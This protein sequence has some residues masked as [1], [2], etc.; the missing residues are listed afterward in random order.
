MPN[1]SHSKDPGP[2]WYAQPQ[3]NHGFDQG[4][5]V[6]V[7]TFGN[8]VASERRTPAL[9]GAL[10][11]RF[12]CSN[13]NMML[14]SFVAGLQETP[15]TGAHWTC[16][17]KLASSS[18]WIIAVYLAQVH[19]FL[20]K[21]LQFLHTSCSSYRPPVPALYPCCNQLDAD[22]ATGSRMEPTFH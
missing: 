18:A 12:H 19:N 1:Q 4:R 17:I 15:I 8:I 9:C 13:G 14:V 7:I 21:F 11:G 20:A 2:S 16:C 5:F 22:A 3:R 10:S 6:L